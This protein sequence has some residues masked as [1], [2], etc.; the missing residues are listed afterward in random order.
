MQAVTELVQE[1]A[2]IVMGEQGRAI[3]DG[4]LEIAVEPSHCGL[5]LTVLAAAI[6]GT[7]HP[8]AVALSCAGIEIQ[9]DIGP[10]LPGVRFAIR[11]AEAVD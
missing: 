8:C 10:S 5:E 9:V 11:G 4:R 3:T 7:T 1:G 2:D 6:R